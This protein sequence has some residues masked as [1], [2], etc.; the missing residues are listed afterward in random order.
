MPFNCFFASS[1]FTVIPSTLTEILL[2]ELI[3]IGLPVAGVNYYAVSLP[4][5]N[6]TLVPS[7]F[8]EIFC[9][10]ESVVSAAIFMPSPAEKIYFSESLLPPVI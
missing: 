2:S 10:V 4:P 5:L 1:T 8:I 3:V 6:F 7:T 9:L